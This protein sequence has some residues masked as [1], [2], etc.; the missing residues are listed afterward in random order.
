MASLSVSLSALTVIRI[1]PMSAMQSLIRSSGAMQ[2]VC[3]MQDAVSSEWLT[4]LKTL[5]L[6]MLATNLECL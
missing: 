3:V 1:S 6:W 5:R 2:S 4:I